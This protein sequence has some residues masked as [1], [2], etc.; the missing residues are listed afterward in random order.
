M[1][2]DTCICGDI[3]NE[4]PLAQPTVSQH[5]K[6]LKNAGIIKGS[7]EGNAICYCVD[8]KVIAILQAY[9]NGIS[10]Q[11]ESKKNNCC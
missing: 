11:I 10:T 9:F 4:L 1:K 6:E 7:I 8:E 5:L 2:V 3:V